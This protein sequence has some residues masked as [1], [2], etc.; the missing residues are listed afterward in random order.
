MVLS[1]EKESELI[2]DN[3][4][5]IYRAV[6]NFMARCDSKNSAVQLSY[7]DCVQEVSI[8]FLEYIRRC[9][10]EEQLKKFPWYDAINALSV[11][12]LRSQPFKVPLKTAK[13]S[14]TLHSIPPTV[15]YEVMVENGIEPDGM[16]KH[17]V[18]DKETELDFCTFMDSQDE[19]MQRIV[20]MR[21]YGLSQRKIGAQYGISDVTV[22]KKIKKL[23]E[24]YD[25]FDKEEDE[26]E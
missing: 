14:K 10:T 15:S 26:D 24:D 6:D 1:P 21:L 5:K 7:D 4:K 13:F 17:W 2:A 8:A 23:K 19:M 25:E 18:A 20:S 12:V 11:H 3:M 16:S 22:M 9:E